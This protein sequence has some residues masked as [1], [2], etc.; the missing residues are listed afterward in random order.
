MFGGHTDVVGVVT[1]VVGVVTVVVG[2][3]IQLFLVTMM[4]CSV[5]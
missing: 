1:V 5:Q 2:V 3:V 4:V